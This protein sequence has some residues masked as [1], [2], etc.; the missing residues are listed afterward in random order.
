MFCA[1]LSVFSGLVLFKQQRETERF[2]GRHICEGDD[3]SKLTF[4]RSALGPSADIYIFWGNLSIL[5]FKCSFSDAAAKRKK[6]REL[7]EELGGCLREETYRVMD[8]PENMAVFNSCYPQMGRRFH[9]IRLANFIPLKVTEDIA[10]NY[11]AVE[12]AK[13]SKYVPKKSSRNVMRDKHDGHP[14]LRGWGVMH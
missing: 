3:T 2:L 8:G 14:Y 4:G 13:A 10:C 6:V 9:V 1:L 11:E 5:C 7:M 12:M